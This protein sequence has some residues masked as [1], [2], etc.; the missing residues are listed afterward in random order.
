M[1]NRS[2]GSD[3]SQHRNQALVGRGTTALWLALRAISR[4]DGPGEVILPDL[5]CETALEGVL[6]AGFTPIFADVEPDRLTIDAASVARLVSPRTRAVLVAHL[7]GHIVDVDAICTAAP[8]VPIIEDAVQGIGGHL[9]GQPVGTLGDL[10]FISFDSTKMISGRGGLLLYDDAT[11]CSGIETDQQLLD[12]PPLHLELTQKA[13]SHLLSPIAAH[14]YAQRL[15]SVIPSRLLPFDSTRANLNRIQ[16]DWSTLAMR[17]QARNAKANLLRTRLSDLPLVLPEIRDGDAI[18]R[19]TIAAPTAAI[20][21]R[22]THAL[23]RA[24]LPGSALYYPLSRFF[25]DE[26]ATSS[27]ANRL[28]NLWVDESTTPQDIERTITVITLALK[29]LRNF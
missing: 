22:I 11:F 27:L 17:V 10:S 21:R 16:T 9:R 4:R 28:V 24:G 23:Q 26:T 19:Y 20:A 5:L 6:L 2:L 29:N 8:G 1:N 3:F 7:F 18:W 13:L 15:Q 25:G 14:A 12:N